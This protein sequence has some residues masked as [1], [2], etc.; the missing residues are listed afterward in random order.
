MIVYRMINK[1]IFMHYLFSKLNILKIKSEKLKYLNCCIFLTC[2]IYYIFYFKIYRFILIE[3]RT[4]RL[5]DCFLK[6]ENL[7]AINKSKT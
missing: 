7:I 6:Q 4:K 1:K 5:R 3:P 2:S